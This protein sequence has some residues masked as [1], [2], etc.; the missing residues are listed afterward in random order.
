MLR[1]GKP[2]IEKLQQAGKV[3]ELIKALSYRK[4]PDIGRAAARALGELGDPRAIPA[5]G[6]ALQGKSDHIREG[7][8]LAL[9]QIDHEQARETLLKALKNPQASVRVAAIGGVGATGDARMIK[10][11]LSMVANHDKEAY[12]HA[13]QSLGN[14]GKTLTRSEQETL[15]VEPL[16]VLLCEN[17]AAPLREPGHETLEWLGWEPEAHVIPSETEIK[18][19]RKR[20]HNA[21]LKTLDAL[22]WEPDTSELGA[23]YCIK[24]GNWEQCVEI[25]IPAI[26]PLLE[27]FQEGDEEARQQA[28]LSLVKIGKPAAE[29]LLKALN[30]EIAEMQKAAFA[31]L[32]KIGER[33]IPEVLHFLQSDNS[34]IRRCAVWALGKIGAPEG[35]KPLIE[36]FFDLDWGVRREVHA[37]LVEI[38]TPAIPM[39]VAALNHPNDEVRWGVAGTLE[40][41]GWKPEPDETGATYWIIKRRWDECVA[42]GPPAIRPL[43]ARFVHWD[44]Y[45]CQ[46][47]ANTLSR[48]GKPALPALLTTLTSEKPA[49]RKYAAITL[50]LIGDEQAVPYLQFL[51]NQDPAEAVRQFA[52]RSLTAIKRKQTKR[53]WKNLLAPLNRDEMGEGERSEQCLCKPA[54]DSSEDEQPLCKSCLIFSDTPSAP[55]GTTIINPQRQSR[56]AK[57][58]EH[59]HPSQLSYAMRN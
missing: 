15:I 44:P 34:D 43:I 19:E 47:A 1:F 46:K 26:E 13:L 35:Y 25:G 57:H 17:R 2:R 48:I 4:D 20:F 55:I 21:I 33:A 40:V 52:T 49:A 29:P 7:A 10:P 12:E 53:E 23:D 50:G 36:T 24:K 22:G 28:Y 38:G 11:L 6:A 31:D 41:L 42:I 8:A 58:Q 45:V 14:I 32:V 37:A 3:P 51:S 39:L 30:N 56:D 59:Y 16:G 18:Q 54:A 5:L 27:V 9:S